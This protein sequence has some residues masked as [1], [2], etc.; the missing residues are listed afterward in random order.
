MSK[1]YEERSR[2]RTV[3]LEEPPAALKIAQHL[4]CCDVL[5]YYADLYYVVVEIYFSTVP[6]K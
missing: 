5:M 2:W 3:N 6:I 4:A 1:A